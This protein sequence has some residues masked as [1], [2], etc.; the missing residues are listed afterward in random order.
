MSDAVPSERERRETK[1][2]LLRSLG[3]GLITGASDD[4]P[5]GIATSSQVGAQ[6]GSG[7]RWSM[8]FSSPWMATIQEVSARLGRVTGH[9]IGGN[10]RRH[11][12]PGWL[13][14]VTALLI[15]ANIINLGAD[16]GAVR[17]ARVAAPRSRPRP[18]PFRKGELFR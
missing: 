4:D 2:H 15:V 6:F 13:W 3:P 18:F 11:D 9:G 1:Q 5:S 12:P 16:S 8:L 17:P 14:S 10:L 7:L